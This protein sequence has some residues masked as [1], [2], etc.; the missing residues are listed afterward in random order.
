MRKRIISFILAGMFANISF[1]NP[2]A[3]DNHIKIDQFGYRPG[4]KKT[5]VI[6]NPIVG[7][8]NSSPFTPG[9]TYQIR[10]WSDNVVIFTGAITDWNGGATH[11]QSGDKVWWFDFS[12]VTTPG[13]YYVFDVT[14][15]V[16]SYQFDINDLVYLNALKQAS[17]VFYY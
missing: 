4:D 15:N 3:V 8:N 7:Y 10:R 2:P 9:S 12:S 14:K 6:S 17:R 1:A 16:G 5:A 13:T 11:T